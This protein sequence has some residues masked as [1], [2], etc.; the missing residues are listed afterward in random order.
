MSGESIVRAWRTAE[1]NASLRDLLNRVTREDTASALGSDPEAVHAADFSGVVDGRS[2]NL[3]EFVNVEAGYQGSD[4]AAENAYECLLAFLRVMDVLPGEV[5]STPTTHY[6]VQD[7][8]HKT[9]DQTYR[10]HV[11]NFERVAAG[12][13]FATTNA[14]EALV[15][16][17][18]F[19][20]VPM[21]ATGHDLLL[22][23][24]STR[25]SKLDDTS[26]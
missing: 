9:T 23:C 7:T 10:V 8:I 24:R 21:S 15:A 13:V 5:S 20:P 19:W 16:N 3:P 4:T 18:V 22:G 6:P 26:S 12:A 25:L 2:V 17:Q 11:N 1:K 14:G